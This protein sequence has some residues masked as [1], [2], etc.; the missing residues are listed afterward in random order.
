[1]SEESYERGLAMR[2]KVLG[3]EHVNASIENADDFT[4]PLQDMVTANAWGGVW[5]R[6]GL[7]LKT[8]SMLT[9]AMLT[10]LNRPHEIKIHL[11]GALRNGVTKEEI[12]EVLLH[13]HAYCGWPATIDA[14]RVARELFAELDEQG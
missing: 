14:F 12:R 10:A 1:M 2:R 4:K 6:D 8:R 3:E 13:A 9:L 5:S 7:S 11:R